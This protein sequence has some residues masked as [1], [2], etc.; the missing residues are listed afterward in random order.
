M[1]RR[2]LYVFALCLLC[3]TILAQEADLEVVGLTLIN[4]DTNEPISELHDGMTVD[5]SALGTRHLS[6]VAHT[7]PDTVGSV[8][9]ALND[10]PI[11]IENLGPYAIAGDGAAENGIDF[12]AWTPPLGEHILTAMPYSEA[13]AGG[14]IGRALVVRFAVVEEARELAAVALAVESPAPLGPA[15][16]DPRRTRFPIMPLRNSGVSGSVLVSDYGT[17]EALITILVSNILAR[18]DYPARLHVGGCTER[19]ALLLPLSSIRGGS[20]LST[21]Y[22]PVFYDGLLQGDFHV[23]IYRA[24]YGLE[25]VV[26]CAELRR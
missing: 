5:F 14:E 25:M 2:L 16:Q 7:R 20:G 21:T 1:I 4:A 11:R 22:T 13:D 18:E 26:A 15:E 19:G 9:F 23:N 10:E 17:G 24:A 6:V 8:V 12:Y 3:G